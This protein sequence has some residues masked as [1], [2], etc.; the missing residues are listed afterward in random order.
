MMQLTSLRY[1]NDDHVDEMPDILSVKNK[2]M[3][4]IS[5]DLSDKEDERNDFQSADRVRIPLAPQGFF[6]IIFLG[7]GFRV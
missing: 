6:R 3:T 7:L 1:P 2:I 4:I 5:P